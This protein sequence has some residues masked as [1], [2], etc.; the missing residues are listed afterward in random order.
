MGITDIQRKKELPQFS[1][2]QCGLC[3]VDVTNVD[4]PSKEK[5]KECLFLNQDRSC[6]IYDM[7]PDFCSVNRSYHLN[8]ENMNIMEW[9][10]I[11]YRSCDKL[12]MEESEL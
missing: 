11:N 7:R 5:S 9:H 6:R 8:N 2:N 3:C 10:N 12:K 1:C 4:L